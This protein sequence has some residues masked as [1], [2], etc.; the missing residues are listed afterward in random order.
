LTS[1]WQKK[2]IGNWRRRVGNHE[3]R[4]Q[5]IAIKSGRINL[6]EANDVA[7][8][9]KY[10]CYSGREATAI[11]SRSTAVAEY[12]GGNRGAQENQ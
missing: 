7:A 4:E 5:G 10:Q 6:K 1:V 2:R 12:S 11:L 9:K 8:R 3:N